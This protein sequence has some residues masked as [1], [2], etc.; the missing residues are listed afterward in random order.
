MKALLLKE[1]DFGVYTTIY[2]LLVLMLVLMI[3]ILP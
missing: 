1:Y 3:V 2:T